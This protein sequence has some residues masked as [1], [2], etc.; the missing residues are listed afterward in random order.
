MYELLC[1]DCDSI[2][3]KFLQFLA[4]VT[5]ER[6]GLLHLLNPHRFGLLVTQRAFSPTECQH[7]FAKKK[8]KGAYRVSNGRPSIYK[9][10]SNSALIFSS[11]SPVVSGTKKYI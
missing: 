11:P 4:P 10:R 3:T 7:L 8:V 6:L 2:Y 1:Y 9:G 5:Q